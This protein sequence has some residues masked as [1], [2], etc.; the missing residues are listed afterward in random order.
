[1]IPD[2]MLPNDYDSNG[3][4]EMG[5][6]AEDVFQLVGMSKG[7]EVNKSTADEDIFSHID[8]HI[9]KNDRDLTVDVKARK[10]ISRGVDQI[11]EEEDPEDEWIWVEFKTVQGKPGWLYG[12][13]NIIAF[14]LPSRFILVPRKELAKLAERVI[15]VEHKSRYPRLAKHRG[16]SRISRPKELTGMLNLEDLMTIKHW[17]WEK[18]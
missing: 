18:P 2:K 14:E 11:D 4:H 8:Y 16:Y 5:M 3:S 17:V 9:I 12:K 15:D 6:V 7:Y 13:A 10:R 1:M